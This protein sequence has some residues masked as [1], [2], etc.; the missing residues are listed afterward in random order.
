MFER[1]RKQYNDREGLSVGSERAVTG[2]ETIHSTFVIL[3]IL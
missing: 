3:N 2:T 1:R